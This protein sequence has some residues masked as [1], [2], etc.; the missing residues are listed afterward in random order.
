VL[1]LKFSQN[2]KWFCSGSKDRTMNGF[3]SPFGPSFAKISESN[4]ILSIDVSPK[5]T[6]VGTAS[7]ENKATVY[8]VEY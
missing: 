3:Y 2:G 4:S 1:S 5:G 6:F 8:K 7:W